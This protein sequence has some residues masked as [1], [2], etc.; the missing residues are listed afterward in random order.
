[1]KDDFRILEFQT[2][3]VAFDPPI[4]RIRQKKREEDEKIFGTVIQGIHKRMV[5]FQK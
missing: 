2:L 5:R 4:L 1:L 3:L